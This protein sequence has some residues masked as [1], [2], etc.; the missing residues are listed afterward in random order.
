MKAPVTLHITVDL[1]SDTLKLAYAY[2]SSIGALICGKLVT[3]G[4][5]TQVGIPAVAMYSKSGK[6][7]FGNQVEESKEQDFTTVVRIKSLISLLARDEGKKR[8]WESNKR[9]YS[10]KNVFPKFYLPG[11]R[12][13]CDDLSAMERDG[14]TFSADK[15]PKQICE[16]FF[17]YVSALIKYAISELE[18]SE[19]ISVNKVDYSIIYPSKVGDEYISELTA[20]VEQA[21]QTKIYKSLSSVKAL[22]IYAYQNG[23]VHDGEPFLVFD[24]GEDFISVAKAWFLKGN[25]IVDGKDGHKNPEE[26]GGS[27]LDEAICRYLELMINDRETIGTPSAGDPR[28]KSEGCLD[29]KKYQLLKDVKCAKHILSRPN[30]ELAY[31]S[32]VHL[33]ICRDCFVQRTFTKEE[34]L[35]CIGIGVGADSP[36]GRISGYVRE[37][38][39]DPINADVKKVLIAGGA[40]E[41]AGV[42]EQL[43]SVIS[44]AKR[45]VG[46]YTFDFGVERGSGASRFSIFKEESSV[47]SAALGGAIVA[48]KDIKIQTV[49]SLSYGTWINSDPNYDREQKKLLS[50]FVERGEPLNEKSHTKFC[51]PYSSTIHSEMS[52][53]SN[54]EVI[55]TVIT[56]GDMQR[57]KSEGKTVTSGMAISTVKYS[58]G[59]N[60]TTN[61]YLRI[62]EINSTTRKA[63][64]K[65]FKVHTEISCDMHFYYGGRR[66]ML[67]NPG[68]DPIKIRYSEGIIV[69]PDGRAR[70][71]VENVTEKTLSVGIKYRNASNSGWESYVHYVR[72][73]DIE[74]RHDRNEFK[75]KNSKD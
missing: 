63:M 37:E 44:S 9:Y 24:I 70:I 4:S 73:C 3:V 23:V 75:T 25:M 17:L 20:L 61:W 46:V 60:D 54:D 72:M 32:G 7:L 35:G 50:L 52:H 67:V 1:G 57:K 13:G 12:T 49:L 33:L 58:R 19:S 43:R 59:K 40:V 71:L 18:S 31:S 26:L 15:T 48:A 30:S 29:S 22:G 16:L 21:F 27:K 51:E 68:K 66:V 47:Y 45:G 10:E 38:L 69:S 74:L 41:T 39:V 65:E 55:S 6:W 14:H 8:T 2:K 42:A 28:H 36:V 5:S 11:E 53:L 64:E 34:L 56:K 62:D